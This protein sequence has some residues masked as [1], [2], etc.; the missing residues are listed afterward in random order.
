VI[1]V[2]G[3][4]TPIHNCLVFERRGSIRFKEVFAEIE[5]DES[6]LTVSVSVPLPL[7]QTWLAL[8]RIDNG[9]LSP[10]EMSAVTS[11][12]RALVQGTLRVD[13]DGVRT[14]PD[15]PRFAF[16][17]ATVP[18]GAT[19]AEQAVSVYNGRLEA[20]LRFPA[21]QTPGSARIQWN[22]FNSAVLTAAANLRRG[23][24]CT[25]HVFSTY[26]P[27]YHWNLAPDPT[28]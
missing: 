26:E 12:V 16:L 7:L 23:A 14:P 4:A 3:D 27:V 2:A 19:P 13:F 17:P 6:G 22:L 25:G 28:P 15:P 8:P 18:F 11:E 20:R 21:S 10:V 1:D 9:F 5:A 24:A